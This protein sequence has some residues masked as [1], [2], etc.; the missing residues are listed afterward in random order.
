LLAL[1][2]AKAALNDQR[3]DEDDLSFSIASFKRLA[4]NQH[5]LDVFIE[6]FECNC[7]TGLTRV[8]TC[9]EDGRLLL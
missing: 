4:L 7:S 1:N 3:P 5:L 9:R 6:M 8:A 2:L